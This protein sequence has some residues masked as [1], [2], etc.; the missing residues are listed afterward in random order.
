MG[1]FR[2]RRADCAD[3]FVHGG[4]VKDSAGDAYIVRRTSDVFSAEPVV[5]RILVLVDTVEMATEYMD[6]FGRRIY[7]KIA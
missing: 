5:E 3:V 7:E 6:A 4:Y 2:A 1:K